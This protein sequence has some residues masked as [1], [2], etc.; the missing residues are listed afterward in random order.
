MTQANPSG[1]TDTKTE[2][3][4]VEVN[5]DKPGAITTVTPPTETEVQWQHLKEQTLSILSELPAYVSVFFAEYRKPIVTLALILAGAITLKVTLA[6]IDALNDIPLLSPTFE[7][8]GIGYSGW[9]VYRYL[10]RASARQELWAEINSF[11]EQIMGHK[12]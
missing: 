9:F 11:K 5:L 2:A 8:I 10:L 1:T 12:S 3:L 6:A 7:L 4:A